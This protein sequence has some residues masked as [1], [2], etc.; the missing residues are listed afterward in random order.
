MRFSPVKQQGQPI[1]VEFD[2]KFRLPWPQ[3]GSVCAT[4]QLPPIELVLPAAKEE[5][6]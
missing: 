4:S 5:G 6:P 1:E 2:F 3:D